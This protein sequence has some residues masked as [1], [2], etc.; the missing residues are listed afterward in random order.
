MPRRSKVKRGGSRA[1]NA[2]MALNPKVC[3]EYTTPV[4]EGPKLDF[5]I[6]DLSLYNTTGGGSC[7]SKKGKGKGKAKS[8]AKP[9]KGKGGKKY[10]GSRAS[11]AVNKLGRACNTT[12]MVGGSQTNHAHVDGCAVRNLGLAQ[13]GSNR[14]QSSSKTD[15]EVTGFNLGED[16]GLN[17][18]TIQTGGA[19]SDWKSTLYS[20]G[21]VN[22]PNMSEAQFRAFTQTGDY[23]PMDS[24]RSSK[25]LGG[26]YKKN[27]KKSGTKKKGKKRT[28]RRTRRAKRGGG[29]SDWRSTVYSRGSYTAPNMPEAQFRAFTQSADYLPNESM[30]TAAFM[31]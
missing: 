19:S 24:M 21:P 25:F 3:M 29:S 14:I 17:A 23:V 7:S 26:G 22:T 10:G 1:S 4:I 6:E 20:A 30:R 31:K 16:L 2:V 13:S 15:V 11:N 5:K 18:Q 12:N 28:K 8:K 9:K 27:K